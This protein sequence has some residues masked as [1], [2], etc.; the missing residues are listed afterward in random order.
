MFH[1]RQLRLKVEYTRGGARM[2]DTFDVNLSKERLTSNEAK[3]FSLS[4]EP[5]NLAAV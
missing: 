2:E 1:A 4:K 5:P 3:F